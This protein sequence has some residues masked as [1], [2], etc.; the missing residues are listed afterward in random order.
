[1]KLGRHGQREEFDEDEVRHIVAKTIKKNTSAGLQDTRPSAEDDILGYFIPNSPKL[2][3]VLL[4][5]VVVLS[6]LV[7]I[8][9]T[10]VLGSQNPD[11]VSVSSSGTSAHSAASAHSAQKDLRGTQNEEQDA[12]EPFV[13]ESGHHN[14][15]DPKEELVAAAAGAEEPTEEEEVDVDVP[16]EEVQD[17]GGEGVQGGVE[18][19]I[20]EPEGKEEEDEAP[21][22]EAEPVEEENK[23][24]EDEAEGEV[25]P[26]AED[27]QEAAAEVPV[28]GAAGEEAEEADAQEEE[29]AAGA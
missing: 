5:M 12:E 22:L 7:G 14:D 25:E 6:S 2:S 15:E 4:A 21:A 9:A 20:E 8:Y 26:R 24:S 18:E 11:A 29:G 23:G 1:M 19:A 10:G 28:E 16:V 13:E 3:M 27:E 17:D